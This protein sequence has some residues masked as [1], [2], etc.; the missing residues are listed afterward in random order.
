MF[1]KSL[2]KDISFFG[3]PYLLFPSATQLSR[4]IDVFYTLFSIEKMML[5]FYGAA[6]LWPKKVR[7]YVDDKINI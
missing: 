1:L 3:Y 4:K 7:F 6:I 5:R 2:Y